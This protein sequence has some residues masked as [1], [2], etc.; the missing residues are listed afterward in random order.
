MKI[1]DPKAKCNSC[2]WY[3]DSQNLMKGKGLCKR[4]IMEVVNMGGRA[5]WPVVEKEEFCE[6]HPEFQIIDANEDVDARNSV[7]DIFKATP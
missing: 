6:E 3:Y 1:I 5:Q 4:S 7:D 2:P